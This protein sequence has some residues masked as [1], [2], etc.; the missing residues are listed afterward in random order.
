MTNLAAI[1]L[2]VS[3]NFI[4]TYGF[5]ITRTKAFD[6]LNVSYAYPN[7]QPVTGNDF[8]RN[9]ANLYF[10]PRAPVYVNTNRLFPGSN[11]FR[12]YVNLN[13]NGRF[14]T[15]GWLPELNDFMQPVTYATN[16]V[17]V[18]NYNFY[19]GDP[20]WVGVLEKPE[21]PHSSSNLFVMRY[22]YII[23]PASKTL[24]LN[25]I[26][27]Y[28]KGVYSGFSPTMPSSQGD[29]FMRN[30]GVGTFEINLGAFLVD[31]NSNYWPYPNRDSTV[32]RYLVAGGDSPVCPALCL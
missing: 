4:N 11:D 9:V 24:D 18:T 12:F 7:G 17:V 29:G 28:A 2:K 31:L 6:P 10:Y 5:D 20:E 8:L 1:D 19:V 30:Q 23:I 13:R 25:Y 15:N 22:A 27:N 16:G 14:D 21:Y 32:S 3:T 26:H